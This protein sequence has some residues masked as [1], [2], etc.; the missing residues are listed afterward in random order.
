MLSIRDAP[1]GHGWFCSRRGAFFGDRS[2]AGRSVHRDE[3]AG[4]E[5]V[6]AGVLC[7]QGLLRNIP[8]ANWTTGSTAREIGS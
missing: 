5:G 6:S 8:P 4:P 3:Y 7:Q 2:I 1:Q